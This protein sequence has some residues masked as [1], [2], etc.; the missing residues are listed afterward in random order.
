MREAVLARCLPCLVWLV[1]LPAQ[2]RDSQPI[3]DQQLVRNI[4]ARCEVLRQDG[5]LVL[6]D[7]LHATPPPAT[8]TLAL[9]T[10]RRDPRDA[11]DLYAMAQA[12]AV[13][14]GVYYQCNECSHWH[15][16]AASGFALSAE[17]AVTT[18]WHVFEKDP[19]RRDTYCV[20]ADYDGHVW[21]I[22]SVLAANAQTD[23][24]IVATDAR[25]LSPLPLRTGARVGEPVWC[26][27]NPDHRFGFFSAGL[28]ARWF[29]NRSG[30]AQPED[31]PTKEGAALAPL[32]PGWPAF[33]VTLDF[34]Q[35][36]SGAAILDGAGNAIGMAQATQSI[37]IEGEDGA[38]DAQMVLKIVAPAAAVR[39]LILAPK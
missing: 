18:C 2:A 9:L 39:E 14:V 19:E 24:C 26:L 33:E 21:P 20:I 11:A 36:S 23:V 12:S 25:G 4:E 29:V 38:A 27:S 10:L 13:L 6:L 16:D 5:K 17:G 30:L 15:F 34:A 7:K 3:D 37:V 1:A 32:P 35:G 8:T 28:I 22:R 31:E